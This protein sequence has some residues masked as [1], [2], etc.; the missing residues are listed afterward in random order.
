MLL[1]PFND[2]TQAR[3]RLARTALLSQ[4]I[5]LVKKALSTHNALLPATA[6]SAPAL[7]CIRISIAA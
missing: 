4:T 5:P 6:G 2:K 1:S 7:P 3:Y